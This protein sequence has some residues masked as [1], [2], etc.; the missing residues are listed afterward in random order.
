MSSGRD[1][2]YLCGGIAEDI[3]YEHDW[4]TAECQFKMAIESNPNYATAHGWYSLFV[5][6]PLQRFEEAMASVKIAQRLDPLTPFVN[7][8]VGMCHYFRR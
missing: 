3:I 2:A 6:I 8:I 1:Q 7:T 5:L 4:S